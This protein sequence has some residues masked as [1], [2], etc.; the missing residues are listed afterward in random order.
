MIASYNITSDHSKYVYGRKYG[1]Q[2]LL[3]SKR[4]VEG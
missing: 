2:I 3:E 4:Q 1:S